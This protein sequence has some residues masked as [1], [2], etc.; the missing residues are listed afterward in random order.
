MSESIVRCP[1][2]A[3]EILSAAIKCKH[4]G[5]AVER[6][7]VPLAADAQKAVE[8][9]T[10]SPFFFR[11]G[12]GFWEVKPAFWIALAIGAVTAPVFGLGVAIFG[13]L[14]VAGSMSR[15]EWHTQEIKTALHAYRGS[16]P[17]I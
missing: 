5:S 1:Y 8:Y 4:C 13:Y 16:P 3:E 10:T 6:G 2:C 12:P 17:S 9:T 14:L 15:S 7:G 11:C